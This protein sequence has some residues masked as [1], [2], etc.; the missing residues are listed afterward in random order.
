M[1]VIK[2]VRAMKR[3]AMGHTP[4]YIEYPLRLETRWEQAPG[5]PYLARIL[6]A[7]RSTVAANMRSLA[8]LEPVVQAIDEGAYP[9]LS[10]I[11]WHNHMIPVVDALTLMWAARG[12]RTYM[13]VGSGNSTLYVKAA[14]LH[15]GSDA[16]IVSIDPEPRA[17]VD[18]ICDEV[19]RERVEDVDPAVFDRLE[20]GDVLFI[21][22]SHRSLM[23]SDVTVCMT[24]I[25]PRLRPGVLVGVH[26]IFLPYDYPRSWSERGYNEQYLLAASLLANPGYFDIQFANHWAFKEGLHLGAL[27]PIWSRL[28][29]RARDRPPSAF[30]GVKKG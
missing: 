30:W 22:N 29:D 20:P 25:L 7:S 5:N 17:D 27:D 18:A 13:E 6:E 10:A 28:G 16:R 4:I 11:D 15:A 8:G 19:V 21:D 24:E 3:L 23:N 1:T 12:A 14:L 9:S 26:D 2:Y